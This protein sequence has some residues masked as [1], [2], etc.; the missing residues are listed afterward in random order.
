MNAEKKNM[1]S[2]SHEF[3]ALQLNAVN[4]RQSNL[5][6]KNIMEEIKK[7]QPVQKTKQAI[8]AYIGEAITNSIKEESMHDLKNTNSNI[9]QV[10]RMFLAL[11]IFKKYGIETVYTFY[12]K[13]QIWC[14]ANSTDEKMLDDF[15]QT[16]IGILYDNDLDLNT[17]VFLIAKEDI[18]LEDMPEYD[19]KIGV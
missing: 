15:N 11:D 8:Y 13:N 2:S 10:L 14:I 16:A 6:L 3:L 4:K 19:D 17:M 9:A 18:S 7:L 12:K 1:D 5:A